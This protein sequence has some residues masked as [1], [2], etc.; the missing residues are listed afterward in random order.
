MIAG[1][2]GKER[3]S[4]P[5]LESDMRKLT[6]RERAD[7][8]FYLKLMAIVV[9]GGLIGREAFGQEL[10]ATVRYNHTTEHNGFALVVT[11]N[12]PAEILDAVTLTLQGSLVF[13]H[14]DNSPLPDIGPKVISYRKLRHMMYA[15]RS[16]EVYPT[17]SPTRRLSSYSP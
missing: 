11:N 2:H 7:L 1:R 9:L 13:D 17:G 15:G 4:C 5:K 12:S 10:S 16:S 8:S 6:P 14:A 3:S